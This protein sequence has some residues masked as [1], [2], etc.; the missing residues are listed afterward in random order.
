MNKPATH[1]A[2]HLSAKPDAAAH[3]EPV[4]REILRAH[5]SGEM[6]K[7][8][9]PPKRPVMHEYSDAGQS[10]KTRTPE[11]SDVEPEF[12][13]IWESDGGEVRRSATLGRKNRRG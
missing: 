2:S 8:D 6:P 10:E 7:K 5:K 3:D 11:G 1:Q 4:K 13:E 9:P 12:D